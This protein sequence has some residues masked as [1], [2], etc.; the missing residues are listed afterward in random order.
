MQ[1]YLFSGQVTLAQEAEVMFATK[2]E[3]SQLREQNKELLR[4]LS[5]SEEQISELKLKKQVRSLCWTNLSLLL[6]QSVPC[7]ILKLYQGLF[8]CDPIR[9]P[10]IMMVN[11]TLKFYII[12]YHC[13]GR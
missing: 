7:Q 4:S 2:R 11:G 8:C 9:D 6:L 5:A 3:L 13:V 10:Q 12:P 1:L